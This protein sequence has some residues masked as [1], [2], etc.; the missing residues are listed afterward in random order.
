LKE[1]DVLLSGLDLRNKTIEAPSIFHRV[2]SKLEGLFHWKSAQMEYKISPDGTQSFV[3]RIDFSDSGVEKSNQ[4]AEVPIDH[5]LQLL[6]DALRE[7]GITIWIAIDRLD[8]AFHGFPE[9]EIPALRALFRS[10]LG[11]GPIK[12][13][14]GG[15]IG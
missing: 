1:L 5:C 10:Y 14:A 13:L 7:A 4:S 6:N 8:E 9:V 15:R 2:L 11:S 3:P 12:V